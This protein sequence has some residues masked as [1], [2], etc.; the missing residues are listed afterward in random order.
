MFQMMLDSSCVTH[1][2]RRNDHLAVLIIV[3]GSGV[4]ACDG[5]TESREHQRV[6]SL[7]DQCDRFFVKAVIL[8]FIKDRR[9]LVC[10]RAVDIDLEVA[11][12]RDAVFF[13]DLPDK[14]EHFLCT[15]DCKGRDDNAST[16]V[17][18][19]LD[20]FRKDCYIVRAF[21]VA[22]VTIG[23]FHDNIICIVEVSRVLDQRLME[24]SDIS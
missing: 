8:M 21:A 14:I 22:S 10:Q 2:A 1:T 12:S 9:R 5:C 20:D 4:I 24:V 17:K 11:M 18:R 16:S 23:G 7:L 13:L 6:D 15:A 3:D 19:M